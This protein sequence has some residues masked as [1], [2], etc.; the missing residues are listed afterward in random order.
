M[1]RDSEPFVREWRWSSPQNYNA[2]PGANRRLRT[3][4]IKCLFI[5]IFFFLFET[6]ICYQLIK[7]H[8]YATCQTLIMTTLHNMYMLSGGSNQQKKKNELVMTG[9]KET[10]A[11]NTNNSTKAMLNDHNEWLLPIRMPSTDDDL[12]TSCIWVNNNLS[13]LV[14][15]MSN[16][17]QNSI[18]LFGKSCRH[19]GG[20]TDVHQMSAEMEMR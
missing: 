18:S 8:R 5:Y 14:G 2:H 15:R 10:N 6:T 20:I 13:Y 7:Y 12:L 11:F 4:W 9:K 17:L 3:Y 19:L 16:E 1:L